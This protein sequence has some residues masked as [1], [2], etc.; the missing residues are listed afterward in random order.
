[1]LQN[2]EG[3]APLLYWLFLFFTFSVM[4]WILESV[5]ESVNHRRIINRGSLSGPYIPVFGIGG[6]LFSAV[7]PPIRETYPDLTTSIVLVFFV[8]A[9][10]A[11][12]LEYMV[13]SIMERLFKKQFWD[14]STMKL[15]AKFTYKN[16]IS[17]VSS[18]FFG[19]CALFVAFWLY[20]VLSAHTLALEPALIVV[21]CAVMTLIMGADILLQVRKYVRIRDILRKFRAGLPLPEKYK[22]LSREDLR[23]ALLKTLFRMG[24]RR[25]AREFRDMIRAKIN[26]SN[27]NGSF[28]R[29]ALRFRSR[30]R[31]HIIQPECLSA[32][33]AETDEI[34][35]ALDMR[36][37][38]DFTQHGDVSVFSHSVAVAEYSCR[39][40]RKFRLKVDEPSLIRGALLHD[41]FG[42]DWH[43]DWDL[44][45]GWKHP[46][47]ALA[48]AQKQF[49]LNKIECKIIRKHMWPM[50]LLNIP[51]CKEAWVVCLVDKYCSLLETFKI[52]RYNF[53]DI[54]TGEEGLQN[55]NSRTD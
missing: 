15:T 11:T 1:M 42:Y 22:T 39:F 35:A 24:G 54:H 34:F 28:G 7:G 36:R 46:R 32:Y 47:I 31:G 55:E 48:N 30:N 18:L 41:F 37:S 49:A 51:T 27:R 12:A 52:F 23:E 26:L 8:G 5:I 44:F 21:I 2:I 20:E 50:T 53:H 33:K 17:L 43:D 3:F 6:V 13:G 19:L 38:K 16:R 4:G 29:R 14:Y 40:A 10:L 45:H 9:L 25:Q